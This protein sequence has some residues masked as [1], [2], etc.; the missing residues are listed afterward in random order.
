MAIKWNKASSNP[1]KEVKLFRE[2][3]QRLRYLTSDE[4]KRLLEECNDYLRPMVIMVL[5]TGMRKSEILNLKWDQI[6][7]GRGCVIVENTKNDE[8]RDI[9]MNVT[10][11]DWMTNVMVLSKGEYVFSRQEGEP[12]KS[13]RTA[14][15]NAVKRA[16][17]GGF[18]FHDIR[19]AFASRLVMS[20]VDLLT[21]KELMGHKTISMTMRYAHLSKEHKQKAVET[22]EFGEKKYCS[23]T[24]VGLK[25]QDKQEAQ[26]V[27]NQ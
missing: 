13:I 20:G 6:D 27:I 4:E 9:P 22:L 2:R 11:T 25:G 23:I 26:T 1:V 18:R 10:L 7:F 17:L 12:P 21:V 15:E 5:H 8:V 24:T 14:F 19:H 16:E 3:N